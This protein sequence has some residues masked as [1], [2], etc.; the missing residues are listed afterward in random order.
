MLG[1]MVHLFWFLTVIYQLYT[2]V[3]LVELF[4]LIQPGQSW[5]V[6]F[7]NSELGL[8][9]WFFKPWSGFMTWTFQHL[10][11]NKDGSDVIWLCHYIFFLVQTIESLRGSFRCHKIGS[12]KLWSFVIF[13]SEAIVHKGLNVYYRS[14]SLL[15]SSI[16]FCHFNVFCQDISF[17]CTLCKVDFAK[18]LEF[19]K[20]FSE[21]L[22]SVG[23]LYK[24]VRWKWMP[25]MAD[26]MVMSHIM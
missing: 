14:L 1:F 6:L 21:Y 4:K 3:P 23:Y 7:L 19:S 15:C 11:S 10:S 12:S 5:P 20:Y 25:D 24:C 17:Q 13:V 18:R 16:Y 9:L 2:C 22:W 26:F 8:Q